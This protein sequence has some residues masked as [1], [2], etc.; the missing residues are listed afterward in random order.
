MSE[1]LIPYAD[2]DA[3]ALGSRL[4]E[5]VNDSQE[6]LA[7]RHL[8]GLLSR[9][10][11]DADTAIA[12]V[13]K[14]QG[15]TTP[16][17]YAIVDDAGDVQGSASIFE[18]LPL[19]RTRLPLPTGIAKRMPLL[20]TAYPYATHNVHAWTANSAAQ[21]LLPEA[22]SELADRFRRY[23]P[24][25][26]AH[27]WYEKQKPW[28]IEPVKSPAHVHEAIAASGLRK[29]RAA[30]FDDAESSVVTPPRSTLYAHI[31]STNDSPRG[32]LRELKTGRKSWATAFYQDFGG[33]D[34]F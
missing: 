11:H 16:Q 34:P 2:F 33:P 6:Q 19:G 1:R 27:V 31:L 21:E 15:E 32:Q 4:H 10:S 23:I 7:S 29:V 25:L 12:R 9:Y 20:Y 14:G 3:A 13:Q 18:H 26:N 22:Y 5:I 8:L 28:T 30:R 17:H 24:D